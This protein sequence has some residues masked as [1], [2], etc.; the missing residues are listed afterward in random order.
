MTRPPL[1]LLLLPLHAL[2]L[3]CSFVRKVFTILTIQLMVT[4]GITGLFVGVQSIK[5][6]VQ[7]HP[8]IMWAAYGVTIAAIIALACCG[9][10]R[11]GSRSHS[12][13][14]T[15]LTVFTLAE[16]Y[17]VGA[18]SSYYDTDL[19]FIAFG[20]TMAITL[21]LTLFASQTKIDFTVYSGA[22][23]S[24]L[25]GVIIFGILCAIFRDRVAYMAYCAIGAVLFSMYLVVDVQMV[26]RKGNLIL[27]DYV[28][29]ALNIYVDV[30]AI[31]LRILSL[32][33]SSRR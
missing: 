16:S 13:D 23:Y 12:F 18:I 2:P 27:D 33:G 30:I 28:F 8:G 25:W 10:N 9:R 15:L 14:M 31:F 1:V 32:L 20:I 29:A 6:A 4:F 7:Q 5:T 11:N 19:V 26:I 17:L 21:S 22:L 24:L 3:P